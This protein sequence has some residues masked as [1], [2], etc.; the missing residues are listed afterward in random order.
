MLF[1]SM[2]ELFLA[3]VAWLLAG[4][5]P[6]DLTVVLLL[7]LDGV[8]DVLTVALFDL[9]E[10]EACLDGDELLTLLLFPLLL[11][12][13][14]LVFLELPVEVERDEELVKELR[15]DPVE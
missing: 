4:V 8:P 6:A 1:L 15:D 5:V 13:F 14:T 10:V 7:L 3:G 11:T 9:V 2:D 12:V